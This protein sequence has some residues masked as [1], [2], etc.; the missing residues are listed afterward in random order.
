MRA[1]S[2]SRSADVARPR[3]GARRARR[4]PRLGLRIEAAAGVAQQVVRQRELEVS[5]E[6]QRDQVAAQV[7]DSQ[8]SDAAPLPTARDHMVII[9]VD[10]E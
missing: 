5:E 4:R 2:A 3:P 9:A 6:H 10:G 8:W 1:S 7:L